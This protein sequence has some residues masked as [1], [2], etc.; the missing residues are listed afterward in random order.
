LSNRLYMH[1]CILNKSKIPN[2][3]SISPIRAHI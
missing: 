2:V 3:D 1:F